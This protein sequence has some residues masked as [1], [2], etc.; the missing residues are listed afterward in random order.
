MKHR[1]GKVYRTSYEL[2]C[3]SLLPLVAN[4]L[5]GPP[6]ATH[7]GNFPFPG[8]AALQS[9]SMTTVEAFLLPDA[10][11]RQGAER[12]DREAVALDLVAIV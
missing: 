9:E 12:A 4:K 10:E 8:V 5:L 11:M 6:S 1:I 2:R 7:A 3:L